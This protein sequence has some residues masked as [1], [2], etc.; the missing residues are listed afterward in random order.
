MKTDYEELYQERKERLNRAHNLKEPDRVPVNGSF[1]YFAA[2]YCGITIQESLTDYDKMRNAII[3]TSV[4]FG[5]DSA[6]VS[7]GIYALPLVIAMMRD[8]G[9]IVPGMIN[10]PLHEAL[11]LS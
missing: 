9:G 1:G 11:G 5:Y 8:Y 6:G 7:S 4:D 3:K 10:I 2:K